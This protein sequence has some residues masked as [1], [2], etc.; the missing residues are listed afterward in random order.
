MRIGI[1][2]SVHTQVL[3]YC[4]ED[5]EWGFNKI[6]H[7]VEVFRED[8]RWCDYDG[9]QSTAEDFIDFLDDWQPELIVQFDGL[10]TNHPYAGVPD[11]IPWVCWVLDRLPWLQQSR[12]I[13]PLYKN[14]NITLAIF[15]ELRRELIEQGYP[16]DMTHTMTLGVN[17]DLFNLTPELPQSRYCCE[18]GFCT[19][20][21]SQMPDS[22]K[23]TRMAAAMEAISTGRR[24]HLYGDG[25]KEEGEPWMYHYQGK[26]DPRRE[27]KAC[28]QQADLTLHANEDTHW[29]MRVFEC[30]AS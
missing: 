3:K 28:F 24:V 8:S 20:L 4:V 30:I 6:G 21:I 15:P 17:T 1:L 9:D 16:A 27:L 25:W 19:R 29:H 23:R 22:R 12:Y 10:R 2:T 5:L 7:K 11:D 13:K 14:V 26:V 18:I